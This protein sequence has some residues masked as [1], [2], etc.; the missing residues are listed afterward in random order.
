MRAL[1][2]RASYARLK[3]IAT[4]G[5]TVR[6]LAFVDEVARTMRF[7]VALERVACPYV[8]S[9]T[10][11]NGKSPR[12]QIVLTF[13]GVTSLTIIGGRLVWDTTAN[14]DGT[15]DSGFWIPDREPDLYAVTATDGHGHVGSTTLRVMAQR[16]VD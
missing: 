13:G 16:R 8:A 11:T 14:A 5:R 10:Y 1:L 2:R 15:F 6:G 3:A 9:K 12:A 7:N 4:G